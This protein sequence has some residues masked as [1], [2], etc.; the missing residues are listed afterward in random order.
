[1]KATHFLAITLVIIMALACVLTAC[2]KQKG[3]TKNLTDPALEGE[4]IASF[5]SGKVDGV[6]ASDGW[7][8]GSVFNVV[9]TNDNVTYTDGAMHLGIKE[10][11]RTVWVDGAEAEYSYTGGEARTTMH[12]GYGDFEVCM[13]PAKK[14]GTASTFFTCTGNY[15]S[16]NGVPNQWDEIDIEFLG[17][18]TTKVQF[19][20]FVNGEGGHEYMYNLGFDASKEY[21]TY[22]FRWTSEYIVWFVDGK[23]VYKVVKS[24]SNPMP[25]TPGRILMNYWCGTTGAEGWMGKFSNAS[26]G[27]TADYKWIRTSAVGSYTD[28]DKPTPQPGGDDE[29]GYTGDWSKV[30]NEDLTFTGHEKYT[31]SKE[32]GATTVSYTE[33]GGSEYINVNAPITSVAAGKNWI[34]MILKNNAE[35]PV[36]VRVNLVDDA[37]SGKKN[38]SGNIAAYMDGVE[39]RTD[40]EW[41]GSFFEIPAG[42]TVEAE[43]NYGGTIDSLELMLDSS[44]NDG[45]VRAGNVT[46]SE[47][48][49]AAQGEVIIPDDPDPVDPDPADPAPVSGNLTLVMNGEDI[50]IGGNV[51][52]AYGVNVDNETS[53][54]KV[55]Y[56]NLAGASYVNIWANVA[57][58]ARSANTFSV[59]LTNN[60][61]E[62]ATI[63]IDMDSET[64]KTNTTACN[65]SAT[66][67]GAEVYTDIEWGGSTFTVPAGATV[68]AK[69]VYNPSE[70]PTNIKFFFDSSVYGDTVT[71][72]GEVILSEMMFEGEA[73]AVDPNPGTDPEQSDF[74][75]LSFD[76]NDVYTVTPSGQAVESVTVIYENIGGQSYR[77]IAAN[78]ATLAPDGNAISV[79]IK[80]NG[81]ESVRLRFDVQGTTWI[82]TGEGS[83]TD[84]CNTNAWAEGEGYS[85]LYTDTTWGG[86]FATVAAGAEITMT[87]VYNGEMDQGAVQNLLI[88]LDSSTS[89][90]DT[91]SGSV[92]FSEFSFKTVD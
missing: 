43:I 81:E 92:T 84:A 60:G 37:L 67:D 27:E 20:Y 32:N 89:S 69:V 91:H 57:Q 21:H 26:T 17:K 41:G 10:E 49:F 78:I 22:G 14:A 86:S 28:Q 55:Q 15:E 6:F 38:V 19:N 4:E 58:F 63:R 3:Q 1:M 65:V 76:S 9:W 64:Q 2:G 62:A 5:A 70:N 59:K 51:T 72:T 39:I 88:Y 48:K 47:I 11:T 53:A 77:N 54:I 68:V 56:K 25:S 40:L 24:D 61:T 80:N 36:Q 18:D 52:D 71:H 75:K 12:Y 44:R 90:A 74:A 73:P 35:T 29:T 82:S 34:R 83:G 46:I 85:D 8:N 33:V 31:I 13:K 45:N 23:P 66:M 16:V 50:T 79:K 87:I 30:A 42:A 7:T